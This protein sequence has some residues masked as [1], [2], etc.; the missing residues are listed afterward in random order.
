MINSR[1][2]LLVIAFAFIGGGLVGCS[3]NI[4]VTP[5]AQAIQTG[6]KIPLEVALILSD[7][8]KT[9][10]HS[11][12]KFGDTWVYSNL[13]QAS[14]EHYRNVLESRF[15][16]VTLVGSTIDSVSGNGQSFAAILDPRIA[17]FTFDIPFTKF[18]VYPATIR[19]TMTAF[20]PNKEIIYTNTT[21][22]VGDTQG[23]PGFDFAA[24]PS[25]SATKAVEDGVRLSVEDLISSSTFKQLLENKQK[26]PQ[27]QKEL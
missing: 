9:Y 22:G 3:H 1:T 18:Q 7:Q 27:T 6:N 8:L 2:N 25:K 14:A 15:Q 4:P 20:S 23:S 26:T 11:E 12:N 16:K 24:N 21:N 5:S 10:Q 19:Y 17:G 13:G